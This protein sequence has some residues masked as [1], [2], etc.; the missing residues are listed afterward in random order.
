MSLPPPETN[1]SLIAQRRRWLGISRGRPKN[2]LAKYGMVRQEPVASKDSFYASLF[3]C[4][5]T[6]VPFLKTLVHDINNESTNLT[7]WHAVVRCVWGMYG[8]GQI[9]NL[10]VTL[11]SQSLTLRPR[12]GEFG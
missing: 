7:A 1:P 11:K 3:N 6:H 5:T 10:H 4:G 8:V 12:P 9:S 2:R